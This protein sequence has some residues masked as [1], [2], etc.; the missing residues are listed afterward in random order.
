MFETLIAEGLRSDSAQ[1]G[2]ID[3]KENHRIIIC[4]ARKNCSLPFLPIYSQSQAQLVLNE[5]HS[6]LDKKEELKKR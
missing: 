3:N 4:S 2:K 5:I 6:W 1:L